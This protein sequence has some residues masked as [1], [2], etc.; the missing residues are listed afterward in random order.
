MPHI[1]DGAVSYAPSAQVIL[2]TYQVLG[3]GHRKGSYRGRAAAGFMGL[4][5]RLLSPDPGL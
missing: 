1:P 5:E 4:R 3:S 2:M